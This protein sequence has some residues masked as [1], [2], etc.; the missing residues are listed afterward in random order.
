MKKATVKDIVSLKGC[1]SAH[2]VGAHPVDEVGV[3]DVEKVVGNFI[4]HYYC[5][6]CYFS[7]PQCSE[8]SCDDSKGE[9]CDCGRDRKIK[10]LATA[11]SE[12]FIILQRRSK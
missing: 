11:L 5:E 10:Q 7:C 4:F 9:E 8:G 12:Q 6:D 3:D 2:D 1:Y